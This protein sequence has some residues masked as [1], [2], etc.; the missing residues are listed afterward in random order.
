MLLELTVRLSRNFYK[1]EHLVIKTP[2][3][4]R[5]A[6]RQRCSRSEKLIMALTK[7]RTTT[8]V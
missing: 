2:Q 6:N 4:N 7:I 8:L 5:Y 3:Q 1:P